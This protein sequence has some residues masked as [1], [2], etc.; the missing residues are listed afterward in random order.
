MEEQNIIDYQYITERFLKIVEK[1][2][3]EIK[4]MKKEYDEMCERLE[5]VCRSKKETLTLPIFKDWLET[6]CIDISLNQLS[7]AIEITGCPAWLNP[8]NI[9]NDFLDYAYDILKRKYICSKDVISGLISLVASENRYVPLRFILDAEEYDGID[10]LSKLYKIIGVDKDKLSQILIKKWCIQALALAFNSSTN[11]V[12]ADGILVLCGKQGIGKTSIV[13]QLG[14]NPSLYRLGLHIDFKD[15]DTLRRAT[16]CWIGELAELE[17]TL[18]TDIQKLKAHITA[19]RDSQR[20]PYARSDQN[21]VRRTSYIGTVNSTD[22]LIDTTGNRRFWTVPIEK[23]NLPELRK[24][25]A[26]NFWR[27]IKQI[28]EEEK[29]N[30]RLN[31]QEREMLEDRNSGHEQGLPGEAEIDDILLT[32]LSDKSS[33]EYVYTTTS[34]FKDC[35]DV[36]RTYSVQKIN[37]VLDMRKIYQVQKRV[38]GVPMRVRFLPLPKNAANRWHNISDCSSN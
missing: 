17:S 20:L 11:A 1:R 2:D 34:E 24:F 7:Q 27:Q 22:F 14:I 26:V 18:R 13:A 4:E 37:K 16:T 36:L 23:I 30:F 21:T 25:K 3:A 15:K 38:N 28:G 6:V 9:A 35:F 32:A 33:Y 31:L 10:H 8:E 19:E 5:T 29:W 12:G